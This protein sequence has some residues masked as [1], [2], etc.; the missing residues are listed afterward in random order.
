MKK[1]DEHSGP[2]NGPLK[3][4]GGDNV[5]DTSSQVGGAQAISRAML[6]LRGV[7][8][9]RGEGAGLLALTRDTG[10]SKPT[11]HRILAALAAEGM[12]EQDPATRRYFLGPECHVLGNI[13]SERF[14]INRLAAPVVARLAHEC[15]DSAFFSLRR[16]VFAVCVLREDGDYPLKTHVLLPGDRHP[17][18][19]GAGSLAILAALPDD[20]VEACL[21]A[22]AALIAA[23][24]PHYSVPLIRTLV[25]EVREQGYAVNRGLVVPGSWG[26][27]V[28]LRDE[29]GQ[30][31][32]ALSIAAVESR[33]DEERQFQLAKLLSRE[34]KR[35][36]AQANPGGREARTRPPAPKP[37]P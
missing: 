16:D 20:E 19:I 8:R 21:Q 9:M 1:Q 29:Q 25:D 22:N 23:R 6:V 36:L 14:G 37:K 35:L 7:S 11:V 10:M 3:K 24:Y 12:V 5:T 27:G 28:P 31:L 15:G 4:S 32:G 18:G 17:L 34:A 30:V 13:A 2:Q 33:M 26:I